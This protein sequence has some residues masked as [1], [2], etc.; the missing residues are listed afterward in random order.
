[1]PHRKILDLALIYY[2]RMEHF[3]EHTASVLIF[4]DHMKRWSVTEQQ[5]YERAKKNTCLA[6]PPKLAGILQVIQE[7]D[8]NSDWIKDDMEF[9]ENERMYVLTNQEK[10]FGAVCIL[11]PGVAQSIAE[12]FSNN[13]YILPSSIHE[14]IIVPDSGQLIP[15]ELKELVQDV[16]CQCVEEEEILSDHIY[17]YDR[18]QHKIRLVQTEEELFL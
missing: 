16:N 5:L 8:E 12:S 18:R 3:M 2:Y 9:C 6:L 11:Y 13:F 17:Y 10:Y 1:M 7:L 15:Q 14:C 4:D